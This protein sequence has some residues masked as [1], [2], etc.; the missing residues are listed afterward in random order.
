MTSK[1]RYLA[2]IEALLGI[3]RSP[4]RLLF[5]TYAVLG[6]ALLLGGR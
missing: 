3:D 6:A 4:L 2:R 1:D 5:I